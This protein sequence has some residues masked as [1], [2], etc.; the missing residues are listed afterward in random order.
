ML[1]TCGP[2]AERERVREGLLDLSAA[3][4]K[5]PLPGIEPGSPA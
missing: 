2:S 5:T 1:G 3:K 4:K